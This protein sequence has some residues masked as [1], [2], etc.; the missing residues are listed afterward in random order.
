MKD[1]FDDLRDLLPM[2][3]SLKSSKWEILSKGKKIYPIFVCLSYIH[4]Y[5]SNPAVEYI[6]RLREKETRSMHEKEELQRELAML[7]NQ[8]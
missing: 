6:D 8:N 7:K 5:Y 1:L 2:D 3:K 4:Y